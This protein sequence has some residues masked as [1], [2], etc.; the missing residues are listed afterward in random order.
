MK[1]TAMMMTML[2]VSGLAIPA[3][4]A[5]IAEVAPLKK[6]MADLIEP[7]E[8]Q[9]PDTG[10]VKIP[11]YPGSL[12]CTVNKGEWGASGWTEV[13]LVSRDSYEK[14]V[15]WYRENLPGWHCSEWAPG[16]L[17]KCSD[18]DPGVAGV[19]DPET[20]NVVEIL[21]N[22]KSMICDVPGVQTSITIDFQPD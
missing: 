20:F 16:I 3:W 6:A 9:V 2:T 10:E 22:N 15:G 8:R 14:V 4:S 1:K 17:F 18:K 12:F 11:V 21:K 19:L 7:G 13:H 5:P